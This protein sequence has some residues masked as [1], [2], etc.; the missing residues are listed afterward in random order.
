MSEAELAT[1]AYAILD[2]TYLHVGWWLTAT[3]ALILATYFAG[4]TLPAWLFA[5]II[6]LYV[7]SAFVSI[8]QYGYAVLET[9]YYWNRLLAWRAA[10]DVAQSPVSPN[11]ILS[12]AIIASTFM[13]LAAGTLIAI[14][15]S[16][17]SW[18]DSR[19]AS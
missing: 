10:N 16:F 5:A 7:A 18:R 17:V 4:R 13:M 12:A 6:L 14:A 1:A 2:L 11:S 3:T 15:Y 19:R 8:V 9:R